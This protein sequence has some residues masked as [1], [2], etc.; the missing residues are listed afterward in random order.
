MDS[1]AYDAVKAND[2]RRLS[3]ILKERHVDMS[4]LNGAG[5]TMLHVACYQGCL[6]TARLLLEVGK[7]SAHVQG[8]NTKSTPLHLAA[9]SG[10]PDLAKLLLRYQV[11]ADTRD[12]SGKAALH[13]AAVGGHLEVISLLLSAGASTR[14]VDCQNRN[15]HDYAIEKDQAEAAR[16][17]AHIGTADDR[18]DVGCGD[19]GDLH[20]TFAPPPARPSPS[21]P[22]PSVEAKRQADALKKKADDMGRI[23]KENG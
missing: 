18:E 7:A 4:G 10:N 3:K 13:Y 11:K 19:T 21:K 8:K 9:L 2:H 23:I 15:P 1:E 22:R 14:V 20:M 12:A 6:E 17:L 16:L 5:L